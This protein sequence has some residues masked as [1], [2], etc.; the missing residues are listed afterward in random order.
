MATM[1][2]LLRRSRDLPKVT[3]VDAAGRPMYRRVQVPGSRLKKDDMA[4]GQTLN[5]NL[6]YSVN[7]LVLVDHYVTMVGIYRE[8]GPEAVQ[9]YEN[10]THTLNSVSLAKLR[11]EEKQRGSLWGK[12]VDELTYLWLKLK[13]KK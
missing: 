8:K 1:D 4:P 2:D 5:P 13:F 3:K 10:A 7:E 11:E 6:V 9:D 12:V